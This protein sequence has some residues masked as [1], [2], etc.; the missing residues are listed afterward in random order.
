MAYL[1][2]CSIPVVLELLGRGKVAQ[3]VLQDG[4]RPYSWSIEQGQALA[5][6]RIIGDVEQ[7]GYMTLL[8]C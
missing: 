3:L 6:V 8:G 5:N 7:S 4:S 1:E 2:P